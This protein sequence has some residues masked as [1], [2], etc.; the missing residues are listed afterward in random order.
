M[1]GGCSNLKRM[2]VYFTEWSNN[3]IATYNWL[4]GVSTL[5]HFYCYKELLENVSNEELRNSSRIPKGWTIV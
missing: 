2:E 3:D 1:F 4:S 5:G